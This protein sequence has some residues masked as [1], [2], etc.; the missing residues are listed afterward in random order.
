[1]D[2]GVCHE[3]DSNGIGVSRGNLRHIGRVGDVGVD[4]WFK[5]RRK[6]GEI[7]GEISKFCSD[8]SRNW[9]CSVGS[10][11]EGF[12]ILLVRME[13]VEGAISGDSCCGIVPNA[14]MIA[15]ST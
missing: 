15:Q 2:S 8:K 6:K 5:E 14:A 4:L 1:M 3:G 11:N 12:V 7:G 13:L 10:E 9:F